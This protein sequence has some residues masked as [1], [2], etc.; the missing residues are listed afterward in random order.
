MEVQAN[1]R[2]ANLRSEPMTR[3][4]TVERTATEPGGVTP[5]K[6]AI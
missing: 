2:T 1:R 3:N 5:S 6:T 4:S